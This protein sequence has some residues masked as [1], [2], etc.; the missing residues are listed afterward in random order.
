MASSA[1]TAYT[2]FITADATVAG[3]PLRRLR[4]RRRYRPLGLPPRCDVRGVEHPGPAASQLWGTGG[5]HPRA[6]RLRRRRRHRLAVFHRG[7]TT[8]SGTIQGQPPAAVGPCRTTSPCPATTTATASPTSPSSTGSDVRASGSIQGQ[9][10]CSSGA[11][12]TTSPCPATTTATAT[13]TSPS[14]TGR[15]LRAVVHPGPAALPAA[16]GPRGRHPRARRLRR[17]RRHRHRRLPPA[18]LRASGA[19]RAS[20]PR[21]CGAMRTTS[22]CPATTTATAPRDLAVF[23]RVRLGSGASRASRCSC[24]ATLRHP[25]ASSLRASHADP[26]PMGAGRVRRRGKGYDAAYHPVS[27]RRGTVHR[28]AST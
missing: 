23:H 15:D 8:G 28:M 3:A 16:V 7:A 2:A 22:P 4:R 21:S 12:R 11:M 13:P 1:S 25:A 26:A 18:R 9:P 6:R 10:P 17:R 24:G 27:G 20:R 5:R 14:S 19:S